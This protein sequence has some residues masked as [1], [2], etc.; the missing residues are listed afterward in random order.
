MIY[1][2]QVRNQRQVTNLL[3]IYQLVKRESQKLTPVLTLS[4]ILHC[5]GI[6]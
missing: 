2:T 3:K 1:V 4:C 6:V 5:L